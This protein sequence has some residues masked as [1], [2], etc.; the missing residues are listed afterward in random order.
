MKI[1]LESGSSAAFALQA[2]GCYLLYWSPVARLM[3][4]I[5]E[6]RRHAVANDAIRNLVG[7]FIALQV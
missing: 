1:S 4:R 3:A 2:S 7:H 6:P 5:D